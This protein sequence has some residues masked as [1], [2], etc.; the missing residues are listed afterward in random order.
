MSNVILAVFNA[1]LQK[2]P[3]V[4]GSNT[5]ILMLHTSMQMN[6]S[7]PLQGPVCLIETAVSAFVFFFLD[8]DP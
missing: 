5:T 1:Y 8:S 2:S 7:F 4:E 3:V 6:S